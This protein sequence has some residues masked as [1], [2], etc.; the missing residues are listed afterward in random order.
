EAPA[1]PGTPWE[2]RTELGLVPAFIATVRESV[3]DPVK[4]YESM[5][6]RNADGAI[7]YFWLTV[8]FGS[9]VAGVWKAAAALAGYGTDSLRTL[10]LPQ[11][12]ENP[13]QHFEPAD[14]AALNAGSAI[15][16]VLLAPVFLFVMVA[17]VHVCSL[18]FGAGGRGFNA[19]LRAFGYAAAPLMLQAIPL[20]G[21][22]LAFVGIVWF[23]VLAIIGVWKLQATEPWRAAASVLAPFGMAP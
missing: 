22:F 1:R 23:A 19:T 20:C 7:S 16:S 8:A 6:A 18:V 17:V 11:G 3:V 15:G 10:K 13:F 14:F 4:F 9:L 2:R 21:D 5:P 12:Q